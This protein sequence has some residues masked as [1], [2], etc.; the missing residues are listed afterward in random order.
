MNRL[1]PCARHPNA[2]SL[3]LRVRRQTDW[4]SGLG[5]GA[6]LGSAPTT[7]TEAS[8][9]TAGSTTTEEE[10]NELSLVDLREKRSTLA[11]AEEG[12]ELSNTIEDAVGSTAELAPQ[13]T[14][15]EVR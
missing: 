5:L 11:V 1:F 9:S 2:C 4:F 14:A 8:T 10:P 13:S 12:D 3:L 7:T 6:L 15:A